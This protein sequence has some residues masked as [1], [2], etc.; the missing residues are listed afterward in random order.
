LINNSTNIVKG[1]AMKKCKTDR[2][3][4]NS[5]FFF[6]A[7]LTVFSLTA[8]GG[9]GGSGGIGEI[10]TPT[11]AVSSSGTTGGTTPTA[12]VSSSGTTGGTTTTAAVSSSGTT[13]GTTTTAAVSSSG[14]TG[15][16]TT[17][18]AAVSSGGS[19]GGTTTTGSSGA[20]N[21]SIAESRQS[22]IAPLSVFFDASGTIDS[23]LT[24]ASYVINGYTFHTDPSYTNLRYTWDFGDGT[25]NSAWS[26]GA[27]TGVTC[28]STTNGPGCRNWA[29]GADSGHVYETP[30]TYT[31]TLTIYDGSNTRTITLPSITVSDPNTYPGFA[32]TQTTC[33]AQNTLPV[34][35]SGGC[36]LGASVIN[37]SALG[38]PTFEG[39][40]TAAIANGNRILFNRGDSFTS[41]GTSSPMGTYAYLLQ[42]QGPGIIGSYGTGALPVINVPFAGSAIKF[43]AYWTPTVNNCNPS[44][45][46]PVSGLSDWRLMDLKFLGTGGAFSY[47]AT[48]SGSFNNVTI[49]RVDAENFDVAFAN[50]SRNLDDMNLSFSPAGKYCCSTVW[51]GWTIQDSTIQN[52]AHSTANPPYGMYFTSENLLIAGNFI[53]LGSTST[54]KDTSHAIRIPYTAHASIMDNTLERSGS[55]EQL[56]KLMAPSFPQTM[57]G[58]GDTNLDAYCAA[59]NYA[60]CPIANVNGVGGGYT[61]WV[62]ESDNKLVAAYTS[63]MVSAAPQNQNSDE[64]LKDVVIER[65]YFDAGPNSTVSKGIL[66]I[67]FDFA[68]R[69]NIF[70]FTNMGDGVA[71][72]YYTEEGGTISVPSYGGEIYN[73]SFYTSHNNLGSRLM[74]FYLMDTNT[75]MVTLKNNLAWTPNSTGGDAM[76]ACV[77]VGGSTC[78]GSTSPQL[79]QSNNTTTAEMEGATSPFAS[80]SPVAASDYTP[81]SGSYAI[82]AG[83]STVP[84]WSDFF[85]TARTGSYDMGAANH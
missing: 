80:S 10:T 11:A 43:G 50:D 51:T 32:G 22:G 66:A 26:N 45:A 74:A 83:D 27:H 16:T 47:A 1:A 81:A 13:G 67:G 49:L 72:A 46:C 21:Y 63:Y 7:L 84:L 33:V 37:V 61:R 20:I 35:G 34:A 82:G 78:I 38:D 58:E 68:I 28:N 62:E 70:N 53:D 12:A 79:T 75:N 42:T 18:T 9:G 14:T 6:V 3:T 8:C 25:H 48:V 71:V 52:M 24:P 73:N 60:G 29:S 31:P 57:G 69:N 17:T 55:T 56:I 30:G 19:T 85:G 76:F 54:T 23:A 40:M 65:N 2:F 59:Y 64:R 39:A 41:A 36:P 44:T 5:G 77:V 4:M 15:G